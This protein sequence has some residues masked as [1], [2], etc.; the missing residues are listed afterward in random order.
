MWP[1]SL[2]LHDPLLDFYKQIAI[3]G[4]DACLQTGL[5]TYI[6]VRKVRDQQIWAT[7][8][9][10]LSVKGT[11]HWAELLLLKSFWLLSAKLD[12]LMMKWNSSWSPQPIWRLY[13]LS[14]LNSLGTPDSALPPPPPPN[15]QHLHLVEK[16]ATIIIP[17]SIPVS[18]L[19]RM[20]WWTRV[21]WGLTLGQT[22]D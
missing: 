10:Q 18:V 5:R 16:N 6:G 12:C 19:N 1:W 14:N 22:I 20:L 9:P 4:N 11:E 13:C 8:I 7:T 21:R 15:N 3:L 17:W 2:T